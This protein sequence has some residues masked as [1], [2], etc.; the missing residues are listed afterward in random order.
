MTKLASLTLTLALALGGISSPAFVLA[1]QAAPGD[2]IRRPPPPDR[3]DFEV[4]ANGDGVPDGWY[5]ARDAVIE[6]EGGE[7]G[8][9]FLRFACERRGRPARLS[10]AFGVDGRTTEAIIVGMWL[11]TK[12][13]ERGERSGEEPSFLIDFLGDELRHVSRGTMGPWTTSIGDRWTHVA[14][15]IS[16]PPS[17]R[18]AILSIGLMGASGRLDVDGVTLKLVPRQS[19]ETTNLVANG[20]FELGDP[21]PASWIVNND[22]SRV[23][24]GHASDSAIELSRSGAKVFT[25]LALPV[26]AFDGL[27]IS[28]QV[29]AQGLRG[30][31]GAG[32]GVYFLDADGESLG[33]RRGGA[34]AFQ[35][36][37]SFDW[38]P[39]RTVVPVP[40]G[41]VRAVLQFEKSDGLGS[42]RV[43][44]VR[45]AASPNPEIAGWSPYQISDDVLGWHEHAAVGPIV[46]GSALDFSFLNP[47]PAGSKGPVVVKDG[48]LAFRDAGRAR[49]FGVQLLPPAAFQDAEK[50]DAL[51]DR[52]AKS[53]VNLV[54][55][56]DLDTA[57][58]P[59]RSLFDDAR[60]D[61]K[62]FDPDSLARLDHLIAALESRGI[63]VAVELLGGR[64]FRSEDGVASAGMLPPG[65]GAAAVFDPTM[66]KLNIDASLAFLGRTNAET[67][68]RLRD[69]P[70]LAWVTLAGE[71]SMF[72]LIDN[73]A[74]LPPK[75]AD[76]LRVRG[77]QARGLPGRR[78]WQSLESAHH[79]AWAEELRKA[80]LK[81]PLA[82]VSHWRREGEFTPTLSAPGLD[83][84]DDRLFWTPSPWV[85]PEAR[86]LLW[87]TDGGLVAGASRKQVE[88]RPYV[89]GQWC[90][91]TQGAWAL[92][93]EAADQLLAA[94]TAR[95]EDWDAL[96]RRGV[97]IHPKVWGD[98]PVGLVGGE[99]IFQIPE[100]AN[101]TPQV[102]SLWPHA[103]SILLRGLAA[104]SKPEPIRSP[105]HRR[106][107][108]PGWDASRGRLV[109]D[110]PY[111]QGVAGWNLDGV[112]NFAT[113]NISTGSPYAVVVASSVGSEPIAETKRL[114]VTTLAR[115]EPTGYRWVDPWKRETADPGRPPLL[116]EPVRARVEWKRKGSV[117]AFALDNSG[118]RVGPA[119]AEPLPN[120]E[121]LAL[122]VDG[123]SATI[124]WE[125][126]AE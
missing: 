44:D 69:D 27:E 80:G 30:S 114:L 17:T 101:G 32:A 95:H 64:I 81:A 72:N 108:T 40:R 111:T 83:L 34:Q 54:R 109:L 12:D 36:A 11:R 87:S 78:L 41:A 117:K 48:R 97:F 85:A 15:R 71:V 58:G 94:A 84:I 118:K 23:S 74:G 88:T 123:A 8:P 56:G 93:Y 62:E 42:V 1:Q 29:K 51:V 90:P 91:Q 45:V 10:R 98:G 110:T 19:V 116:L 89:V 31:G 119:V 77:E 13:V 57:Y 33:G 7:V 35:W 102:Y 43:D 82:G 52:L 14:K 76:E 99:D 105:L 66:A 25:G 4:D 60:D 21:A 46:A 37:G 3:D 47:G 100:V 68:K 9:K 6:H 39:Q 28:A 113:L 59:S 124:H 126:V 16:L 120:G 92:P 49:F 65:G 2:A 122:I 107:P 79:S 61:T 63:Y 38:T 121:G 103:A 70:A 24:P 115:V 112:S 96:V 22:A 67:G 125:L 20:D 53:G 18:D 26:E 55:I 104:A 86:S 75:Y 106:T 50:V 5:N 73:P